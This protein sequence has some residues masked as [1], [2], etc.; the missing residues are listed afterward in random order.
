M[1]HGHHCW[2]NQILLPMLPPLLHP[3]GMRKSGGTSRRKSGCSRR[4][5]SGWRGKL[6]LHLPALLAWAWLGC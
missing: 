4:R 6:V 3:A 5:L 2:L 1:R